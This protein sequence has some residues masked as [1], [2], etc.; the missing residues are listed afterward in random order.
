MTSISQAKIHYNDLGTPVSDAFDDVYFSNEN[1]LAETLYVFLE[2]NGL[3]KRWHE[4]PRTTFH[5]METGFGT[6][7][8]FLVCWRAFSQYL[9]DHPSA[10]CQ[11]LH[12]STFEKYPLSRK[13]LQQSLL[14]WP[15]LAEFSAQLLAKYPPALAGCHRLQWFDGRITLDLWL[16][17]VHDNMPQIQQSQFVD[18]WFL[19]G[20]A[21]SKN[22]EMWQD[23]LWHGMQRLS[24]PTATVATFTSAGV[25]RRGLQTAGFTVSKVKGFG[26]KR[27]MAVGYRHPPFLASETPSAPVWLIGGGI[28]SLL[29]AERLVQRGIEVHLICQDPKVGQAASHNAQGAFYPQLQSAL[30][31]MS[32]LHLHAFSFAGRYYPE[33][34]Q[35]VAFPASF[36]GVLQLATS[37]QTDTRQQKMQQQPWPEAMFQFVDAQ[38]ASE[39][40]GLTLHHRGVYFD[41]GGWIAPQALCLALHQYLQASS[42]CHFHFNCELQ[43]L[44]PTDQGWQLHTSS[45]LISAAQVVLTNGIGLAQLPQTQHLPM[46]KVRGQVSHIKASG[47]SELKT[48]L[49]HQ[50][51]LTP[52]TEHEGTRFHSLGATFDR[53]DPSPIVKPE[54]DDVNIQQ[55]QAVFAQPDWLTDTRIVGHKAGVRSTV[56]DHVPLVGEL[57]PS[58]YVLGGF[59]ARGLL[60][61]PLLAEELAAEL[62]QAPRPMAT[63]MR[64]LVDVQ[65]FASRKHAAS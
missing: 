42:R 38:T 31:P 29:L 9:H 21:P 8:N 33:L 48:V 44:T 52:A 25:V 24:H 3:P 20:F 62:E 23:C 1:G 30:T 34:Q 63:A 37:A 10:R 65:R 12:F 26:R 43:A 56:L 57:E 28:A 60:F 35:R 32:A 58:L 4:H 55:A 19:D 64:Q 45:G 27:E 17:D 11:R 18:A 22:P 39:L 53:A 6:G 7:L 41:K 61:A 14:Q 5:V 51:Y 36:C 40:A 47:L 49:C 15:E 16:G 50:G 13:D 54:D 46:G 59:G 2:Q